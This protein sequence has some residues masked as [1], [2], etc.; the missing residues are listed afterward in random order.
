LYLP[1]DAVSNQNAVVVSGIRDLF[2]YFICPDL[3]LFIR[4]EG[5]KID[6]VKKSGDFIRYKI[7]FYLM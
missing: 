4:A 2:K 7:S 1:F 5:I 6:E 3:R